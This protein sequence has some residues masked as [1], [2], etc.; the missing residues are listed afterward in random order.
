M[1][2]RLTQEAARIM[3]EQGIRDFHLAK[4]KAAE[5]LGAPDTRNLP[6]NREIQTA[7]QDYQRLFGGRAQ[8]N[9]L[10]AL[11]EAALEAMQFFRRFEPRLVGEVLDGTAGAYSAVHLHVF[12]DTPEELVLFLME[13]DIPFDTEERRFRF[14]DEYV[15]RPA[16]RFAAGD[17]TFEL[18]LFD[19]RGLRQPPNSLV[20]GQAMC[21]AGVGELERLLADP[22]E[23][24][25]L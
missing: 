3:V 20:D 6:Q 8:R 24:D 12:A 23:M 2:E 17:V 22:P 5:R 10:R 9:R 19:R 16:Y 21:R 18:T 11:R 15:F 4:R 7:V 13:H 25:A 1:R 14:G